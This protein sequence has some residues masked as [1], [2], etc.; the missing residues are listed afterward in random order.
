MNFALPALPY[1]YDAL[2]PY[3]DS[4][5]MNIHHTKHHQTYVSNLNKVLD[6]PHGS[7]LKGMSLSAIQSNIPSLPEAIR[8]PVINSGG[9]HYNHGMFWTIMAKPG[10]ANVMPV[11]SLKAKIDEDFGSFDEMKTKFN[12]AAAARFG[13]G[14]AWLNVGADGKLFISSTAN[15]ENPLMKGVVAEPGTPVLGLDVWEH[16]YYLKYQNRRPEYIA[17]FWNVVNW[18]QVAVNF[19]SA[20]AGNTAVFDTPLA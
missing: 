4:T 7:A 9:G 18:D 16:A 10:S 6:G 11:G 13:S 1:G 20:C 17:A 3:V 8:T 15:Q 2:E 14:W 12:G 5:T 19:D